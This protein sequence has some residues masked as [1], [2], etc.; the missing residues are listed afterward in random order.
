MRSARPAAALVLTGLGSALVIGFQVP[1]APAATTT[2]PTLDTSAAATTTPTATDGTSGTVAA[3]TT[4][5]Y[6]DGVYAGAA[7]DEP[8]GT[9]QVQA[10]VSGG[11]LT[12]VVIVSAPT[13]GHSSRINDQAVP[14]LTEAV[15]AA[16]SADVDMISGAT[17]TSRSYATSLQAALDAAA[18]AAEQAV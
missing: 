7:V 16:Q 1:A 10:V 5:T 4:T 13:D 14:I 11:R 17:W 8:W 18:A 3:A 2:T 15:I 9:F 6:A 12:D